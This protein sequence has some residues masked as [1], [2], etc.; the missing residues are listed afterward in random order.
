MQKLVD[1]INNKG[2]ALIQSAAPGVN[3]AQLE[4]DLE[5]LNNKWNDLQEK[6]S[7]RDH[8]LDVALLQSG[9][10]KEALAS[11]LEWL[12][13]TEELMANQKP[14]ASDYKVIKA[15][16]QEQKVGGRDD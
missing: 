7:D 11:L 16:M 12:G 5:A 10:F 13:E 6:L 9:K 2:Q 3:T 1:A 15:Q 14:P 8:K 4:H